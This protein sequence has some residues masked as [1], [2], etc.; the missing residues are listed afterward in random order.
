MKNELS[1]HAEDVSVSFGALKVLQGVSFKINGPDRIGL[2]GP[3]GAG[4]TT[5]LSVISGFVTADEGRIFVDSEEVTSLSV[6]QRVSRGTLR[7]FQAAR[8]LEDETVETNIMLGCHS[9][10]GPGTLRELVATRRAVRWS[11]EVRGRTH[12]V[13]RMVGLTP[14]LHRPVST[15][16]SATRRLVEIARV[17]VAEPSLLLLDEPAA[18][19]DATERVQL[20]DMLVHAASQYPCLLMLVEHDVAI[21]RAVCP[22]S[23]VLEAGRLLAIGPTA[24]VLELGSV[25]DAYFGGGTSAAHT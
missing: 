9:L 5:L 25:R 18:G 19:L 23:L 15:L 13:A 20:G 24:E 14:D 8:L 17:L 4:K 1:L 22:T 2:I 6:A 3:N 21:V 12:A 10:P 16:P 7:T 11:R